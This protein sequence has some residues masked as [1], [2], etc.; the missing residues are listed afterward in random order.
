M[1]RVLIAQA[2]M[3]PEAAVVR[4]FLVTDQQ[5]TFHVLSWP[6]LASS[7]IDSLKHDLVIIVA[8]TI[9]SQA[10]ILQWLASHELRVP[11]LAVLPSGA[12]EEWLDITSRT[13]DD[14][15][16]SPFTVLE[17]RQRIGRLLGQPQYVL[18]GIR[19][20]LLEELGLSSLVG[21]DPGFIQAISQLPRFARSD[22][23]VC[24][25]GETGTGKELCAR[26]LHHLSSRRRFPFVGVDCAA[27][28]DQLFE[29]EMFGH[30]RGAFTDAHR[31]HRGLI[32]MAEGG[33]LFLDEIDSLALSSQAK[34]LRFLQDRQFRALGS[35]HFEV[36]NVRVVAATNR[37]LE[38][39]VRDRQFRS[40][41]FFRLNVLRLR[42]SPLRER[43]GDVELLACAALKDCTEVSAGARPSFTQSALK[44][45]T[46]HN[47]PGNVRELYN[48][49]QRAVIASEGGRILPEHLDLPIGEHIANSDAGADF[50]TLRAAAVANFEK[51]YV[52]DLLRKH[53][54]NVT[55]AA[56][57][58]RQD[59]RAFRR[60]I[61]KYNIDRRSLAA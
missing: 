36:S 22:A 51:Q 6:Q 27:L 39:A 25:T 31:D 12:T 15:V 13:T 55:H 3:A 16:V 30:A 10:G 52:E 17:L 20:C 11:I 32:A 29:N 37:D 4:E 48:V 58:A 46:L 19:R 42:L 34:L 33:T 59:R 1:G 44:A 43:G 35:D 21:Q 9:E 2:G 50:R 14:F 41:L 61:R 28:P 45:L 18:E 8:S 26:A 5:L 23:S 60:F 38:S 47:W 56:R 24:I 57:E 53:R 40:D 54:G 7:G 49:V